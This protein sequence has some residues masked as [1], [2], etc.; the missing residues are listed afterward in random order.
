MQRVLLHAFVAREKHADRPEIQAFLKAGRRQA[1]LHPSIHAAIPENATFQPFANPRTG[2]SIANH[3]SLIAESSESSPPAPYN[4]RAPCG[5]VT[6]SREGR[7]RSR[8]LNYAD[9]AAQQLPS[10]HRALL[11]SNVHNRGFKRMRQRHGDQPVFIGCEL[12]A[13]RP[14]GNRDANAVSDRDVRY[15][16]REFWLPTICGNHEIGLASAES[17]IRQTYVVAGFSRTERSRLER[18]RGVRPRQEAGARLRSS[19]PTRSLCMSALVQQLRV[20][21]PAGH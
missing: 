16:E 19:A 13:Y 21:D 2:T 9:A 3:S 10:G 18:V 14:P 5:S 1:S 6:S 4:F 8:S 17:H 20:A 15:S 7:R 12:P 11:D